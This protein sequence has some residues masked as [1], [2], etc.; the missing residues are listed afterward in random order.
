MENISRH[1]HSLECGQHFGGNKTTRK[2]LQ[3]GFFWPTLYKDA[4]AFGSAYDRCQRMRECVQKRRVVLKG[5][6]KV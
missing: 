4:H 6:L 3:S 1:C 5:I 2:V